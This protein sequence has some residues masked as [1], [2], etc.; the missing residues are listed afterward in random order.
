MS[1]SVG[2]PQLMHRIRTST[3]RM[4]GLLL[5]FFWL[6]LNAQVAVAGHHCDLM[7]SDKPAVIQHQE[8]TRQTM[9]MSHGQAQNALCDKHCVPDSMQPDGSVIALAALLPQTELR[10]AAVQTH[11]VIQK[12]DWYSPPIAGPPTEIVF[13][14]F[15]E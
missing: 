3:Q 1:A 8:H 7:L 2:I 4:C 15:R 10:L 12:S 14:R 5:V 13:C 11:E 6:I 9:D